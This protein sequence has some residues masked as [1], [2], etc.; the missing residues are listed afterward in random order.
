MA[1][2]H[3]N[4]DLAEYTGETITK[5]G[6]TFFEVRM[7]EGRFHGQLKCVALPPDEEGRA[8]FYAAKVEEHLQRSLRIRK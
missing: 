8:V 2:T 4:G 5:Y 6:G 3:L 1:T 7:I